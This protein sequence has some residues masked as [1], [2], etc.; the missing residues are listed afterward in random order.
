M[1]GRGFGLDSLRFAF[2][3]RSTTT[4]AR[5][6]AQQDAS[7]VWSI[8]SAAA[9]VVMAAALLIGK[10]R[11]KWGRDQKLDDLTRR[12]NDWFPESSPI[13]VD[14]SARPSLPNSIRLINHRLTTLGEGLDDLM[15]ILE[16]FK[17]ETDQLR[18]GVAD[19]A[20]SQKVTNEICQEAVQRVVSLQDKFDIHTETDA[21]NFDAIFVGLNIARPASG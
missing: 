2:R 8:V 5:V 19:N 6:F 10:L 14:P 20:K 9:A 15:E 1:G 11:N 21:R 13:D 7:T 16:E 18:V 12:F 4:L 17:S 3:A